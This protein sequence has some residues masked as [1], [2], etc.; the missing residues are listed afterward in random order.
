LPGV[1]TS[2]DRAK[3][4]AGLTGVKAIACGAYHKLGVDVARDGGRVGQQ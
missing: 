2:T 3:A 1:R 4:P